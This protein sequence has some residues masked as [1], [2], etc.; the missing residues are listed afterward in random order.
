MIFVSFLR[1]TAQDDSS[2]DINCPSWGTEN[3]LPSNLSGM[4]LFIG[5]TSDSSRGISLFT[6]DDVG[7][8]EIRLPTPVEGHTR[9][10][11]LSPL[12]TYVAYFE[13]QS[14]NPVTSDSL[15]IFDISEQNTMRF[16]VEVDVASKYEISWIDNAKV[17]L[18]PT[19]ISTGHEQ[20]IIINVDTSTI[21]SQVVSLPPNIALPFTVN[22]APQLNLF[23][24]L[25]SDT[26]GIASSNGEILFSS[27]T[28]DYY[29]SIS[30]IA[31]G[32]DRNEVLFFTNDWYVFSAETQKL[33]AIAAPTAY[34]FFRT[35]V[36]SP[37]DRFIAF[38]GFR[39]PEDRPNIL[40][41]L[42]IYDIANSSFTDFC[43]IG[44]FLIYGENRGMYWSS[45]SKYF[46]YIL[47]DN[48]GSNL[49]I[50]DIEQSTVSTIELNAAG[51]FPGI[52][53]W[54]SSDLPQG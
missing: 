15:T 41:E 3:H 19:V 48:R 6:V 33:T 49:Y 24:F 32:H 53:G 43:Q 54:R 21:E 10:Y 36:W 7:I 25:G 27:Q 17:T 30:S 31:W 9:N 18:S 26:L 13:T 44:D 50:L 28:F 52:L 22:Y 5:Q 35:G 16:A 38:T 14:S 37:N 11:A 12:G 47:T 4:L 42:I 20:L 2:I 39:L 51:G 45:D 23:A 40:S 1:A 46:A 34:K 29:N 8:S